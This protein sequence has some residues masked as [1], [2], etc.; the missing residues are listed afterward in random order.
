[1]LHS[2]IAATRPSE[3]I[4]ENM[5]NLEWIVEKEYNGLQSLNQS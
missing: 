3:M 4:A 1:M 2:P 5:W